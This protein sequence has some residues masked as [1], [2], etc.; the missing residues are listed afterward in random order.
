MRGAG[1]AAALG[2]PGPFPPG[3]GPP[4]AWASPATC[5]SGEPPLRCLK[6]PA[7]RGMAGLWAGR[8]SVCGAEAAPLSVFRSGL[9]AAGRRA[10]P[11]GLPLGTPASIWAGA[12]GSQRWLWRGGA[13]AIHVRW[14][15]G[16]YLTSHQ[17]PGLE[18]NS[19]VWNPRNRGT[20]R[21]PQGV[22]VDRRLWDRQVLP[23]AWADGTGSS[24]P[25]PKPG[26]AGR[27][28]FL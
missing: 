12:V 25:H 11:A 14:P 6:S 15:C 13:L 9:Q 8:V 5:H 23:C 22:S 17:A 18:A 2:R 3:P 24:L 1:T 7:G 19:W 20:C 27:T 4:G 21:S 26:R 16:T 28:L 10:G